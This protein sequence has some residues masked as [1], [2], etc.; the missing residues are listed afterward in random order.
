MPVFSLT[1]I[2]KGT[3][4]RLTLVTPS[5]VPRLIL[6]SALRHQLLAI[7]MVSLSLAMLLPQ[8]RRESMGMY[9]QVAQATGRLFR[10]PATFQPHRRRPSPTAQ[11]LQVRLCQTLPGRVRSWR[12]GPRD[13]MRR[14]GRKILNQM[15]T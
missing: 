10:A 5:A 15:D 14:H 8:A 3:A 2:K 6:A 13:S 1:S 12:L 7:P 4:H 9:V 11:A